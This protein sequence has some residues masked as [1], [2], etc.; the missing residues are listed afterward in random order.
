MIKAVIIDDEQHCTDRLASL[1]DRYCRQ[2]ISLEGS[3]GS[4]EEGLQGIA[5]TQPDLVFLDIQLGELTGFD[6]L[7]RLPEIGFEVI[8][9]T[10]YDSYAIKA[11]KFSAVDYLLKPI[12]PDDLLQAV[13][14]LQKV[15]YTHELSAKF[16]TLLHNLK[17][18]SG[19]SK[20]ITIPTAKGL[21]FV[22]VS[23]IVRCEADINYTTVYLKDKQQIVVAKTLK[24]FEEMLSEH[25]FFRVHNSHLISLDHIKSYQKGK[26]GYVILDDNTPIEVSTRRKD[27]FLKRM[28]EM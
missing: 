7:G 16:D 18:G 20:R 21:V 17:N 10:A 11:F 4:V 24:E 14:K 8:F 15:M 22:P 12:D 23:D 2:S 27:L 28:E 19:V 25:N 26:G 5:E 9:T 1:L 6:L 3:Y 13:G